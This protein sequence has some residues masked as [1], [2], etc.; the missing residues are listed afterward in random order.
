MLKLP[1]DQV[2]PDIKQHLL[3][4]QQLVLQAPP[5]AGKTTAVPLA[6]L[7]QPWL[8]DKKIIMLE[9]RRL[10]ARN[11]ASRMAYLLGEKVGQTVGYQIRADRCYSDKTKILVVTE[12]I[13][14]RKLQSD[15]EL[16]DCAL[17]IFDEFH[18]RNL[19][20]DLSLAFCL[21]SQ[22]LL[23]PDL[24]ILVMS[25]TLNSQAISQL[26]NHATVINSEGRSYPVEIVFL[27][28][29]TARPEKYK[30]TA[31]MGSMIQK[32]L[33]VEQ[34]N[35]LVFLPGVR[36]IRQLESQL[37]TYLA[38][39]HLDHVV[40]APL[41]GDLTQAQQDQA[42]LPTTEGKRKIVLATN[43]AE[44]S[45]TIEGVNVV[46]DSGL[47]R[48]SRF[49]PGSGMN[50]LE[51]VF[52]SQDS[53]EQRSGRAGRL[54]AGKCYRMWTESQHRQLARHSDAEILTSD[55][56]PFML[57][58]AN[59]GVHQVDEL[60]W[61][62]LPGEGAVAQAR[63]LLQ[64]LGALQADGKITAHGKHMLALGTHP[65]LAHMML[66]ALALNCAYEACLI[67]ALLSEK[68]IYTSAA[69]R[70]SDISERVSLLQQFKNKSF[71]SDGSVDSRQAK[72][73]IETADLFYQ[74]LKSFKQSTVDQ[75]TAHEHL[76]GVLLGFA[77][78]DRIGQCRNA[79]EGRYLLSN[80]KGAFF[81]A[82][83]DL[84]GV[85]YLVVA[86]LDGQQR[87]ARIY[88]AS[89]IS[90]EQIETYF[91]ELIESKTS[92]SWNA[93]LQR[94]E[95][96]KKNRLG[97]LV[98]SES[99]IESPDKDEVNAALLEGIKIE[100][101][102]CLPWSKESIAYRQ[103]VQF[104]NTQKQKNQGSR[105]ADMLKQTDLPDLSDDY[106][107]QNLDAWL[108]PHLNG[109]NSIKK[110]QNLNLLNVLVSS[111]SWPQQKLLDELAPTHVTVPSGSRIA[112]DYS[113]PEAPTLAV[114][115]QELF[116][117]QQ[118]PSVINGEFKLLVHL[119]SPGYQPMQVTQ[120]LA[121]FWQTTYFD[122]KKEL[123]GRYKKHYWP[124]DPLTAQ[125][126]NKTKRFMDIK[127]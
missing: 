96:S 29:K 46:I 40:L 79:H 71:K 17:V 98:L 104:L 58:L 8:A 78:P 35:L 1:V 115:L 4:E 53:A 85:A 26:M 33:A 36:E 59:W 120:D 63:E 94:V 93:S 55:L 22:E 106:L 123:R 34:G 112:I 74:Q 10:A 44:T 43:I 114:R 68:D 47:Q 102:G 101:P 117:Q 105:I 57:E 113:D 69:A 25:A 23:R 39:Q 118:T 107:L 48:V 30:I 38:E 32:I 81:G 21:Q 9:P 75:T 91:P 73:V 76:H 62:D 95:A 111:V 110:L 99:K 52:I 126:T 77:Y 121:S 45:L 49:N 122:V 84:S 12:G 16:A 89:A 116:G 11:A 56:S 83:D 125:A 66:K 6:L 5:G 61:L 92:V 18:E 82:D 127:E 50:S 42:I 27:P 13:L 97:A 37:R 109:Q 108:L 80:G 60:H 64:E 7:D 19:Q 20:A 72:R 2:I 65:R 28:E 54:R 24:K 100:G 41:Y 124:D 14:T 88:K 87:E 15:P 86:D 3:H 67:A 31:M 119:L 103:R 51:T 70:S 90:L